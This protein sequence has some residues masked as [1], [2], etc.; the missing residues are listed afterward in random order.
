MYG[1]SAQYAARNIQRCVECVYPNTNARWSR[2]CVS[3]NFGGHIKVNISRDFDAAVELCTRSIVYGMCVSLCV[4][5]VYACA[6]LYIGAV[7]ARTLVGRNVI[8]G[9]VKRI[10]QPHM[11]LSLRVVRTP[12][13]GILGH[14]CERTG[15]LLSR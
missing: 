10:N 9:Q 14:E 6:C 7:G 5:C 8:I 4:W 3:C 15:A 13:M 2:R 1:S 12:Y 11:C